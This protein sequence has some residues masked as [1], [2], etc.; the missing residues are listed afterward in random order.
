MSLSPEGELNE[1]SVVEYL[2]RRRVLS[3]DDAVTEVRALGGGVSNLVYKVATP[4]RAFVVKQPRARLAVADEW[5]ADVARIERERACMVL[6]NEVLG[7]E[8]VPGVVDFDPERKILVMTAAPE[9][10]VTWKEQLLAGEVDADIAARVGAMLAE[11]HQ[12]TPAGAVAERLAGGERSFEELRVDPYY[13]TTA[14]RHPD[15]RPAIE[16]VLERMLNTR[17]CLVHG[18]YSPKNLLVDGKAVMLIDHEVAHIGDPSFDIAFIL[19]HLCL[20]AIYR[21]HACRRFFQAAALVWR[22]YA[23]AL[24]IPPA[25]DFERHVV[26]QLG[27][28][29]IARVDG[30]SPV[31]YLTRPEQKALVRQA[32]RP[33]IEGRFGTLHEFVDHLFVLLRG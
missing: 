8:A 7:A 3:P 20:K 30:K 12:R 15:L 13:R 31:E 6:L 9:G 5:L 25:S 33:A 11:I 4:D 10:S 19:N 14:A 26:R 32:A 29:H 23:A 16:S 28:L 1:A 17:E 24:Q 22:R 27:C 21:P 2:R 18:D